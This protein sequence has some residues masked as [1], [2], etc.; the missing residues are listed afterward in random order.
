MKILIFGRGVIG[1]LYGWAL[2][3]AGHSVEFYVRPGR[4][5]EYGSVLPLKFYDARTK[6][7]GELVEENWAI[8]MREDLP[9]DHDYELILVS[10]QHYHFEDVSAFLGPRAGKATLLIF[11]NFWKDPQV[12]V[13]SLPRD[14]LAWGF[15]RAG[16]GFGKDGVLGG[17]LLGKVQ[18][19][20]FGAN[21]TEREL[22]VYDLFR[23]GGFKIQQHR[24]FRGWLWAHFVLDAGLLSQA[25]QA[26]GSMKRVVESTSHGKNAILNIR[27][28]LPVLQARGVDLKVNPELALAKLPPWLGSMA[29]QTIVKFNAPMRALVESH[30]NQEELRRVCRDVLDEARR[31]GISVPR[32]EAAAPLFPS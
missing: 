23:K 20:T 15:P 30:A 5:A 32:L 27:E 2:E 16:G 7:N 28:L 31:L 14:Q 13:S 29:F 19:G 3:K 11:N 12:S 8:R 26:G 18:F 10:V 1:T 17:A 4:A 9:A 6:L 21:P 22:A 24:A 25:L